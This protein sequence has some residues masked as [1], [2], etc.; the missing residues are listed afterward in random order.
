MRCVVSRREHAQLNSMP[1]G[2]RSR[3]E[4]AHTQRTLEGCKAQLAK[5]EEEVLA[6]LTDPCRVN[7]QLSM[8]RP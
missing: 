6:L 3:E 5:K 7:P 4:H 8:L 1:A 2:L